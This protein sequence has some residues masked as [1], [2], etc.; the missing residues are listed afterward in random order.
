MSFELWDVCC[1]NFPPKIV[2]SGNSK[3]LIDLPPLLPSGLLNK[4][5]VGL[6]R[7]CVCFLCWGGV[8]HWKPQRFW[9]RE[10]RKETT[11]DFCCLKGG[12]TSRFPSAWSCDS[13]RGTSW[14]TLKITMQNIIWGIYS[15]WWF[16]ISSFSPLFW[17]RFPFWLIFFKWVE[18]TN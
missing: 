15:R 9:L 8:F 13:W 16:Q 1:C 18:T 4:Q 14:Q 5:F 17:G 11:L 10:I 3:H 6:C 12:W 2:G 7:L